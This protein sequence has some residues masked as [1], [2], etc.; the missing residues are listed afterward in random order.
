MYCIW[1]LSDKLDLNQE[2]SFYYKMKT[3][4]GIN[5]IKVH[6][7]IA[8]TKYVFGVSNG[9]V[10]FDNLDAKGSFQ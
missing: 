2:T 8:D 10:N 1:I 6:F 3:A 4:L 7:S 9:E 5:I